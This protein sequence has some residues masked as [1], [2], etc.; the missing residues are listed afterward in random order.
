MSLKPEQTA[1]IKEAFDKDE[2]AQAA[3]EKA[4]PNEEG[5]KLLVDALRRLQYKDE[6]IR[7]LAVFYSFDASRNPPSRSGATL[8]TQPVRGVLVRD[9]SGGGLNP[10]ELNKIQAVAGGLCFAE[11]FPTLLNAVREQ[12]MAC[13]ESTAQLTSEAA[14]SEANNFG[15]FMSLSPFADGPG[16]PCKGSNCPKHTIKL[17]VG[18]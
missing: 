10:D 1:A 8:P 9:G 15:L 14:A 7:T 16:D 11:V 12:W 13:A 17:Q 2:E 4:L 5:L 6:V 3:F 18:G